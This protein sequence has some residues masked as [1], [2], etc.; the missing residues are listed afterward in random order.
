MIYII[1]CILITVAIFA[2]IIWIATKILD[3][4]I[5]DWED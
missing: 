1:G 3:C 5:T 2:G 4:I